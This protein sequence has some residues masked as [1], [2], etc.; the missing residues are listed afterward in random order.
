MFA[1]LSLLAGLTACGSA[2]KPT[3]EAPSGEL[4][5]EEKLFKKNHG[6]CGSTD[7]PCATVRLRSLEAQD[8]QHPQAAA[9]IQTYV[10]NWITQP[11]REGGKSAGIEGVFAAVAAEYDQ[12][13]KKNAAYRH[14][15]MLERKA[16]VVSQSRDVVCL[17]LTEN[18]DLGGAHP[19]QTAQYATFSRYTGQKLALEDLMVPGFEDRLAVMAELRFREVRKLAT[20]E[21]L[22]KAG[23]TFPDGR[24]RISRNYG[25]TEKGLVFYYNPYEIAPYSAGP[26]EVLVPFS[27]VGSF[28]KPDLRLGN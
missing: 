28:L 8:S 5:F 10:E 24:F 20:T 23:F 13:L 27:D 21:D 26:T 14:R 18:Q 7:S 2:P 15:W 12:L 25:V 11:V 17:R 3:T 22:M 4:T 1:F 6:A 16:E 9:A 19:L